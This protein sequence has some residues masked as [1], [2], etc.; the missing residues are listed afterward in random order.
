MIGQVVGDER[1]H[2]DDAPLEDRH[3]VAVI[4]EV[5]VRDPGVAIE[6]ALLAHLRP[7]R[8]DAERDERQEQVNQPDAEVFL[9]V[10][11]EGEGVDARAGR[12]RRQLRLD[13]GGGLAYLLDDTLIVRSFSRS[14]RTREL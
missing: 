13:G 5:G 2:G 12:G 10:A 9:P 1:Q 8:I 6:V 7:R 11:G 3:R 4:V 14:A